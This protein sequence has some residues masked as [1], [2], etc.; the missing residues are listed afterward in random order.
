M[1]GVK[2]I[3]D[4]KIHIDGGNEEFSYSEI[5]DPHF[6]YVYICTL[7][8]FIVIIMFNQINVHEYEFSD[9]N[10]QLFKLN[11]LIMH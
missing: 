3:Y 11:G 6:I 2:Q 9:L 7:I 8:S 5:K 10:D 4:E 1:R